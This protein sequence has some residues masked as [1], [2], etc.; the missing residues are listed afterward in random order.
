MFFY[1][2]EEG[3][4]ESLTKYRRGGLHPIPLGDVLP[5]PGTCRSDEERR[6][7]YR[8]SQ[9]LGFGAFATVWLA[10]DLLEKSFSP[11]SCFS[12][13]ADQMSTVLADGMSPSR[14]PADRTRYIKATR[15]GSCATSGRPGQ[16]GRDTTTASDYLT[17]SS[18]KDSTASMSALS[19]KSS[20]FWR[21]CRPERG[22]RLRTLPSSYLPHLNFFTARASYM[23]VGLDSPPFPAR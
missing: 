1:F 15:Y 21:T 12:T 13:V 8:I 10:R 23:V 18:F 4:V 9:K 3:S 5:K 2:G 7:R 16:G 6:P 11:S 17:T 22:G 14:S 20:C 19:P